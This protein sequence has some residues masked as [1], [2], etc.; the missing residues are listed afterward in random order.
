M[1]RPE[2]GVEQQLVGLQIDRRLSPALVAEA[3]FW[4]D[5]APKCWSCNKPWLSQHVTSD[6]KGKCKAVTLWLLATYP[7]RL[8]IRIHNPT[9]AARVRSQVTTYGTCTGTRS[10][11]LKVFLFPLQIL[12]PPTSTASSIIISSTICRFLD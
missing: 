4:V 11:Y 6:P 8:S 5:K 10:G 2:V 7:T 1:Q 3:P 12:I 9:T